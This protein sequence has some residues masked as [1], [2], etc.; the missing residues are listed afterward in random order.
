MMPGAPRELWQRL[1]LPESAVLVFDAWSLGPW[2]SA[3]RLHGRCDFVETPVPTDGGID[4][5]EFT[6]ELAFTREFVREFTL[7]FDDV[8]DARIRTYAAD[9][10]ISASDTSLWANGAAWPPSRI[11][12]IALGRDE[13]RSP[14]QCLTE[15]FGFTLTYGRLLL[16]YPHRSA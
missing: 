3:W 6:P 4:A 11:L 5:R 1:L 15:H 14:A 12:S 8:R 2:G 7:V 13:H 10:D 16:E 9:R